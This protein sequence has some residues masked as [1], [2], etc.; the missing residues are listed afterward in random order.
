VIV[1]DW[2]SIDGPQEL[3]EDYLYGRIEQGIFGTEDSA[4]KPLVRGH[5]GYGISTA[6]RQEWE[7]RTG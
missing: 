6:I 2:E 5:K 1:V 3:A 7:T 4:R